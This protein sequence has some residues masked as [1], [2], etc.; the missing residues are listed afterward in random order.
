MTF[1]WLG[2]EELHRSPRRP[3]LTILRY[4]LRA[5]LESHRIWLRSVVHYLKNPGPTYLG[6]FLKTLEIF[7]KWEQQTQTERC[8]VTKRILN[9]VLEWCSTP[10]FYKQALSVIT[11]AIPQGPDLSALDCKNHRVLHFL[12]AEKAASD[13]GEG[14]SWADF[15]PGLCRNQ[16][17]ISLSAPKV[18]GWD[19]EKEDFSWALQSKVSDTG[20]AFSTSQCT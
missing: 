8:V 12:R 19:A 18:L 20:L 10:L 3:L 5:G 15:S 7:I 2:W 17:T 11:L 13:L 9:K 16:N 14:G 4:L 1:S 6:W